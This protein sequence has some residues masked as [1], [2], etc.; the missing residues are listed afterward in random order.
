MAEGA[1]SLGV[2]L[3]ADTRGRLEHA[4]HCSGLDSLPSICNHRTSKL[5]HIFH[6]FNALY[7]PFSVTFALFLVVITV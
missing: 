1:C 4:L 7:P 3:L 6:T 5:S 2:I